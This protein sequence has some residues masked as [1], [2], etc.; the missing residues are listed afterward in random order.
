M[1]LSAGGAVGGVIVAV[2]CPMLLSTYLELPV[3]LA[4]VTAMTFLMFFAC[5]G[6]RQFRYDWSA[7]YRLRLAAVVLT[8]APLLTIAV[9]PQDEIIASERNFFGVLHV[10]RDA[11]GTRLV[12]GSTIHGM[13][14]I[15]PFAEEPTTYYG[16]QSGIGLAFQSMHQSRPQLKV[17]IVGLGCG[18]LATYGRPDDSFDM[19]EIN[20]SVLEI[21][22]E[23]FSFL[24][25]SEST[26]RTHLGD[27]R[28]VLERMTDAKFD[29][30]VLDAFS[31]DAIP[32]HL[33][34]LEAM[35]LYRTRL[36]QH[37]VL[38]V[39]V[40]NNHLDLVPL[41]HRLSADVGLVS[42]VVR[43]EG[44]PELGIQHATWLLITEAGHPLWEDPNLS[45]AQHASKAELADAPR[46]TDQHHN[47]V[48]VLRLW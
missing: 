15:A 32:A 35:G 2:L 39:H 46:W 28:L 38:A 14:R 24:A 42:G 27:G 43:S 6:W 4:F 9:A 17:G 34:T 45:V 37:G 21:A 23:H 30:L 41:V 3:C 47:V 26:I 8:V 40:S 11:S 1:L 20:P 5:K 13:Q 36:Q 7:A 44:N 29:L 48:S 10:I 31:S 18:V 25:D 22:D 33:L 16:R 19:V 12:H